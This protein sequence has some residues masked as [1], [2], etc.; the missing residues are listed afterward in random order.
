MF[1][2]LAEIEELERT[3][4]SVHVPEKSVFER[5]QNACRRNADRL[6]F[7]LL[8]E[9]R[10]DEETRD[11]TYAEFGRQLIQAA[12]MFRALGVG[13][14][15]AVSLLMPVWPETFVAM[16]GAQAAGVANPVNFLLEKEHLVS[17][18]RSA[19]CRVLIGPDPEVTPG[20][21][22]RVEQVR[23]EI[24]WPVTVMRV[25]GPPARPGTD[26][27]HFE[28]ELARHDG[29]RLA[30][31]HDPAPDDVASLFHTGGTTS[32]PRLARHTQR[33]L[34]TQSWTNAVA[35]MPGEGPGQVLLNGLP[36]F[37][38]GGATCAGLMPL[39]RGAT[40]VIMTAA[41][42]RNPLVVQ[43]IWAHVARFRATGL[44]M[45]PTSWGAA[46]N[47]PLDGHDV[48]SLRLIQSGGSGIAPEVAR[49]AS[50]L[51]GVPMVEGWG[52]TET[53]G[54]ATMNPGAGE[55]RYGSIGVRLPFNEVIVAE[56]ADGRVKRVC[57]PDEI[58]VVLVRGPQVF[59]G[60]VDPDQDARAWV[61]P[62]ENETRPHWSAGGRWLDTGDL[63]RMD[64]DG[65]IWLTGR[66]K[67]IIIRS[68]H[69]IDPV[70]I[71][72]ALHAHP[73]VEAAAAVGRPD[74]YAGEMPVG[75]VQLKQGADADPEEIREFVRGLIPERAAVPAEIYV[76]PQMPL[77]AVGKIFKP[78]LRQIAAEATLGR[79]ARAALG[80][81]VPVEVEVTPHP[82][83]GVLA[84]L[85]VSGADPA[86]LGE[87]VQQ[88]DRLQL[89]HE[90]VE[91]VTS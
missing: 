15:D 13:P 1:R 6:A 86:R 52:M 27:L 81:G 75:F 70:V 58:G 73:A 30:F 46:L 41:G 91:T 67:D 65:Y 83:H 42:Y 66:A 76:L 89:R 32:A 38:V 88:L 84:T 10:P 62:M 44:G 11:V 51:L 34:L 79:M 23:H 55:C 20:V 21:W 3:P 17:L 26:A 39:T 69:N 45:V 16:F 54:F 22:E 48:S 25:G 82:R 28:T 24:G 19:R 14:G 4:L 40:I 74:V 63:G 87:L 72:E 68:G 90:I 53:H 35:V 8:R 33:G 49:A 61:E 57:E 50:R 77:T 56:I 12:N 29:R 2:N 78:Q 85:R 59:G 5:L 64:A 9:G 60:Y 80:A 31:A 71:E 37:H 18:L 47:V 36:P 43:N 7:R